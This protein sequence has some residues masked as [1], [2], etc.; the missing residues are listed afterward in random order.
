MVLVLLF[1][2]F[3]GTADAA[4][5]KR[6]KVK[7]TIAITEVNDGDVSGRV[8][9]R[10]GACIANRIVEVRVNNNFRDTAFTDS[11]G[12]W[13]VLTNINDDD[14]VRA[15]VEKRK[16]RKFV[17]KSASDT[18]VANNPTPSAKTLGVFPTAGGDVD[19][20]DGGI[21]NCRSNSGDCS[22][23]YAHGTIVTL[24]ATADP[25]ST[26]NGWGGGGCAGTGA[27]QV[28]MNQDTNVVAS[29]GDGGG[30]PAPE[31]PIPETVPEPL[32]GLLC[33]I[34]ELLGG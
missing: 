22:Q 32:R 8:G 23:V 2:S 29:F 12:F 17:C 30:T 20:N 21:V 28:T 13:A 16:T 9:A 31:C 14:V 25:G 1:T 4:K 24:T 3:M 6:K 18:E 27:C 26:F 10:K 19:S 34:V 11:E 5:R 33:T 7:S 15:T